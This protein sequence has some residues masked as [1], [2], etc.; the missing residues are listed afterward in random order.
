M[1]TVR[2]KEAA[3]GGRWV[4]GGGGGRQWEKL[5]LYIN[6]RLSRTQ[7]A[8]LGAA[9]E[10]KRG[11]RKLTLTHPAK[12]PISNNN[13]TNNNKNNNNNINIHKTNTEGNIS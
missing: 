8:T 7:R 3:G 10:Y 9:D 6:L 2:R 11:C 13:T 1:Q 4:A 5:S 12:V